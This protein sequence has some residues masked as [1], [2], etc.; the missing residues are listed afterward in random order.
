MTT[1]H[2]KFVNIVKEHLS[3]YK[4]NVLHISVNGKYKDGEYGHILPKE[5][6]SLNILPSSF[7][8]EIIGEIDKVKLH[9][10]FPHLNSSQA[11]CFNLFYPLLLSKD[12]KN[13]SEILNDKI[14]QII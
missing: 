6:K 8:D 12:T 5:N 11:L 1:T 13:L 7:Y 9:Q 4:N 10:F 3:Q 2:K 14:D